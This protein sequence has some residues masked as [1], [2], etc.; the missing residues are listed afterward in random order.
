[1]G[2]K[3]RDTIKRSKTQGLSQSVMMPKDDQEHE[4]RM[5]DL[6]D[7]IAKLQNKAIPTQ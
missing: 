4:R 1:M 3:G 2:N 7:R 6:R 5:N